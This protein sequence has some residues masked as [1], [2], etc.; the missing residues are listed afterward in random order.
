MRTR[1]SRE[2]SSV[3]TGARGT[4]GALGLRSRVAQR[5]G[6]A[7]DRAG[8]SC[9]STWPRRPEPLTSSGAKLRFGQQLARGGRGGHL[10]RAYLLAAH[11]LA[12]E[13]LDLGRRRVR[14]AQGGLVGDGG[15]FN[16]GEIG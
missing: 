12:L 2:A 1:S 13:F 14:R 3:G 8:T 9:F 15:G 11:R 5:L 6:R 7:L 16:P 10:L 4:G